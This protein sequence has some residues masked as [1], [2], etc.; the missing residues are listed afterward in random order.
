MVFRVRDRAYRSMIWF[1][2]AVD[3]CMALVS[4][5]GDAKEIIASFP[6]GYDL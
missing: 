4:L 1:A 6:G 2:R 3:G 5:L